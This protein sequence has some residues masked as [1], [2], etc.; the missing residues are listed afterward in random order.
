[1]LGDYFDQKYIKQITLYIL[2]ILGVYFCYIG[3]Y[4]SDEDT[5][6]MIYVFER[7]LSDG[8]FVTSRFTGNPIPE[9]GI[10]FLSYFFGSFVANITTFIFFVLGITLIYLSLSNEKNISL[11]LLLCLSNPTLFFDNLEPIDYSWALF[12][13]SLGLYFLKKK[14]FELVV[15][16]FAFSIGSRINFTLFVFTVIFFMDF[17]KL[18]IKRRLTIFLASFIVGGLFYLP[19]W[20]ESSFALDW[21]TSARPTDQGLQGLFARFIYKTTQSF[22]YIQFCIL[23]ITLFSSKILLLNLIKYKIIFYTIIANLL[24]F[25]Y[26]PAELSYLQPCLI[27]S[28]YF[29][30]KF[31]NKKILYLLIFVNFLSW[32]ISFDYLKIKYTNSDLCAPKNATSADFEIYLKSGAIN[33]FLDTRKMIECWANDTHPERAI[34]IINGQALR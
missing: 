17:Y 3:G 13:F 14:K 5:L 9:L 33:H 22:G 23:M 1:M 26:I 10:G 34:K 20:Y 24:I 25:F 11:F 4:G 6:P 21:L 15:L 18:D 12:P 7:R 28:Y 31:L 19:I 27:F 29:S 8:L 30:S 32:F 16:F 2:I